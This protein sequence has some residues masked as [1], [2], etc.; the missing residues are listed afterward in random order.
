MDVI[1]SLADDPRPPAAEAFGPT[2]CRLYAGTYRV[3]Y[4]VTETMIQIGHVT[5]VL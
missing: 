3:T 4:D 5:R 1:D 2:V